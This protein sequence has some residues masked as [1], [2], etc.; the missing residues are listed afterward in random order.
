MKQKLAVVG[1]TYLLGLLYASVFIDFRPIIVAT[2]VILL[3]SALIS[4][5]KFRNNTVLA[6]LLGGVIAISAYSFNNSDLIYEKQILCDSEEHSVIAEILEKKD[7]GNDLSVYILSGTAE[8]TDVKFLM[9]TDDYYVNIGDSLSFIGKFK[10]IENNSSFRGADYYLADGIVLRC[11]PVSEISISK[12]NSKTLFSYLADYR[13]YIAQRFELSFPDRGGALMKGIFLGDKTSFSA[14]ERYCIK[15][16]GVAHIT[17]VSGMH[18]TLIIHIFAAILS[19]IFLNRFH[20]VRIIIL[21]LSILCFMAFFGFTASVLRAGIMLIIH[22]SAKL[23]FR[24]SACLNSLGFAILIISVPNPLACND[25]GF[26]LS[27]VTTIG[28]GEIAPKLTDILCKKFPKLSRNFTECVSCS[29]CASLMGMPLSV[30][31]FEMFS[32]MGAFVTIVTVPLFTISLT[33][34]LIFALSGGIF[35]FLL[36]PAHLCCEVTSGIFEATALMPFSHFALDGSISAIA[37]IAMIF[38]LLIIA[39][40]TNKKKRFIIC[41]SAGAVMLTVYTVAM[42]ISRLLPSGDTMIIPRSDGEDS[43][44]LI[45]SD[46]YTA[47]VI[48]GGGENMCSTLYS[49]AMSE[50]I[51]YFDCI[52]LLDDKNNSLKS[53]HNMFSKN[54]GTIILSEQLIKI[55][56]DAG[57]FTDNKLCTEYTLSDNDNKLKFTEKGMYADISGVKINISDISDINK[58]AVNI[59]YGYEKHKPMSARPVFLIDKKQKDI[60]DNCIP[61]YCCDTDITVT[62]NGSMIY[63][64]DYVN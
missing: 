22:Y 32:V 46:N 6:A 47:A 3:L 31:Y 53:V 5:I 35:E 21:M 1:F 58:N 23:F 2:V 18:L 64:T 15:A 17:A 19:F 39:V 43:C 7:I 61:L 51:R 13:E 52:M 44:V 60:A 62:E 54:C 9:Y 24:E 55:S 8:N 37:F 49:L 10:K 28:A 16:A 25:I 45:S 38:I 30:I 34:M 48:T 50:N 57:L 26:I 33:L 12:R 29:L 56:N 27:V 40:L 20:G 41:L 42:T 14:Y 11:T 4:N 36:Y 63:T 59:C